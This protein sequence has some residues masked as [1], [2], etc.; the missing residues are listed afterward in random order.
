[1]NGRITRKYTRMI[2]NTSISENYIG[3]ITE[4]IDKFLIKAKKKEM[5]EKFK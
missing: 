5:E 3:G 2:S 4:K 1:M